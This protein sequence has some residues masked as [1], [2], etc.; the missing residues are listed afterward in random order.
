MRICMLAP[1]FLPVWGGVGAYIVELIRHL[2]RSV[3]IHVVA[4]SRDR[5]GDARIRTSDYDFGEYF[6]DNIRFHFISGASDTFFYNAA[7]QYRCLRFV[8][9][10]VKEQSID[11]IHSHAAHMPDILLQLRQLKL[12]VVTTV[13]TTIAGQRQGAKE[14]GMSFKDLEFSEKA[15]YVSYPLLSLAERIFFSAKNRYYVTVSNWMKEQLLIRMPHLKESC[16]RVIP[17]SVDSGFFK[18]AKCGEKRIVL[19]TGRFTAAK[20]L[21]YVIEAAPAVLNK[22]PDTSFVFVGPG[23][24]SPYMA[25]REKLQL[26][27]S[28]LIFV[29]YLKDRADLLDLYQRCTVYVAPTLYE[30]LPTRVLE[31]MACAKPVVASSVCGIP[32]A[33]TS[34][35][36]GMLVP[37]KSSE[38][39]AEAISYLLDDTDLRAE[40]GSR[41]RS[42]VINR[43]DWITN[44][45]K[46]VKFYQEALNTN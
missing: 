23:D 43:F 33:V 16:I 20:G 12:P 11:L 13:H 30:N 38:A 7:F 42:T 40:I 18:P 36:N 14:S 17:N 28:K 39:L 15:T 1:E 37:P 8:P 10:L 3:E 34:G 24:A 2:P 25:M 26:P 9:K 31:A 4:S 27:E 45:R 6:S 29:G 22:F 46:M 19:F 32:E 5:L 21:R 41:A 35:V 44:A